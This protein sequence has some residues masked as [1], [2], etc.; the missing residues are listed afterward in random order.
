MD[1]VIQSDPGNVI[2][3][4]DMPQPDGLIIRDSFDPHCDKL[5]L[6][7]SQVRIFPKEEDLPEAPEP[8]EHLVFVHEDNS[9]RVFDGVKWK[10]VED[11]AKSARTSQADK[12]NRRREAILAKKAREKEGA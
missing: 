11:V 6:G 7:N 1:K 10:K 12:G 4:K 5:Q 9:L 8:A 3:V 2:T